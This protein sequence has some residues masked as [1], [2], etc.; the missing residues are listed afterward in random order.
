LGL[1]K[2]YL[3]S[4]DLRDKSRPNL[5]RKQKELLIKLY[6]TKTVGEL[7]ELFGRSESA[8]R[9]QVCELGLHKPCYVPGERN[10]KGGKYWTVVDDELLRK[11]Y[12]TARTRDV[13]ARL[14]RPAYTVRERAS[15]LGL[16]KDR[17]LF[18]RSPEAWSAKDIQRLKCLWRQGHTKAEIAKMMGRSFHTVDSLLRKLTKRFGL[19]KRRERPEEWSKADTKYLIA[20]YHKES[21]E[22]LVERLGR[23][24]KAIQGKAVVLRITQPPQWSSQDIRRLQELWQQGRTMAGIAKEIGKTVSSV[25]HELERQRQHSGLQSRQPSWSENDVAYLVKHYKDEPTPEICDVLGRTIPAVRYKAKMLNLKKRT[26][27][28]PSSNHYSKPP[29]REEHDV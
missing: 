10:G 3:P 16:K 11:L 22:Q 26:P 9:S 18:T 14:D 6:P 24:K 13:A 7:A 8:I 29:S 27:V 2:N 12:P 4:R 1:R 17:L 15:S 5:W 23:T 21:P 19:Q 25:A 28:P 20:N